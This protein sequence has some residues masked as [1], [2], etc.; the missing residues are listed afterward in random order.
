MMSIL[1]CGMNSLIP[2]PAIGWIAPPQL[3]YKDVFDIK[4]PTKGDMP[5]KKETKL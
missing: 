5:L 2:T 4:L 1:L 3:F